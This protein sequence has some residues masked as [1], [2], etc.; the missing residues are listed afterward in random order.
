MN[1]AMELDCKGL[2]CPMP[3]MKTKKAIDGLSTGEILKMIATDP[4][5][6]NDMIAWAKRTGNMLLKSEENNGEHIFYVQKK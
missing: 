6:A 1:V 2:N 4:G 5:S 3:I